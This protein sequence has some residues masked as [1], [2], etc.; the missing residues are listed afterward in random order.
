MTLVF[1]LMFCYTG[2][3]TKA[4]EPYAQVMA[5]AD[6]PRQNQETKSYQK[7]Q[8]TVHDIP[9]GYFC[10]GLSNRKYIICK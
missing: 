6:K 9:F 4:S 1:A 8:T 2:L 5:K 7:K 10:G 3:G